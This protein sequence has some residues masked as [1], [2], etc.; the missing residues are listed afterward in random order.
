MTATTLRSSKGRLDRRD[1]AD[2][3]REH[4]WNELQAHAGTRLG[5]G[6]SLWPRRDRD[7]RD[8]PGAM[9]QMARLGLTNVPRP[10]EQWPLTA[11]L[12]YCRG[13]RRRWPADTDTG[14]WPL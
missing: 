2:A 9:V 14:R 6:L 1:S 13:S 10:F 8:C 5:M 7:Q 11:R 3:R 4:V 12:A